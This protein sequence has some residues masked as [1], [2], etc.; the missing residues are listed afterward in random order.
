MTDDTIPNEQSLNLNLN[1]NLNL[2]A[3][4]HLNRNQC[5]LKPRD[6]SQL[7]NRQF[8]KS[9]RDLIVFGEDWGGQPSSTQ[10]LIKHLARNRKVVWINSIGLR[11][12]QFCKQDIK[13]LWQ[14][15]SAAMASVMSNK[16][17]QTVNDN[18][19]HYDNNFV[20][21]N[22]TTMPAPRAAITRYLAAQLLA[23][24]IRQ[25]LNTS[26]LHQ[27]VLWISLP[28]AVDIVGKLGESAVVYY[29]CD[30]FNSLEGVDH[31]TVSQR[32]QQL[33]NCA[34]L[35]LATSD[36]LHAK[37]SN[38]P[39]VTVEHG[40]D[41]KLFSQPSQRAS[42]LPTNNNPTAGYY[43]SIASWLDLELLQ[44]TIAQLPNWNFVFIGKITV[45]VSVLRQY[46]NVYFIDNKPHHLLPSYSQH[47]TASLLPFKINDQ[48]L[49]CNPFKLREYLA[50]G[51]PIISTNFPALLSYQPLIDVVNNS[52]QMVAALQRARCHDQIDPRK[53][54]AVINHTWQDRANQVAKL[55]D[56]L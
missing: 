51:R 23:Y 52:Q 50:A 17:Q 35:I 18:H 19:N 48:I 14:K 20:V 27:P 37:F 45:D 34:D 16:Q 55:V 44:Q 5:D 4:C 43:G 49:A 26:R 1:Q 12:P 29:C 38:K 36:L 11:Q 3:Q 46:S 10:Q 53:R 56:N 24:Q 41:F 31:H 9:P 6:N 40:V 2:S 32:E 47:W 15:I 7:D 22:P 28:T 54:Q 30:D 8:K 39:V 33:A 13:R 25:V 42:D 21:I